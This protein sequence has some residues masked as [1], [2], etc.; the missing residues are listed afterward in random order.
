MTTTYEILIRE[1]L[2]ISC[3]LNTLS[4]ELKVYVY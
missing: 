3:V 2:A 1:A 4:N